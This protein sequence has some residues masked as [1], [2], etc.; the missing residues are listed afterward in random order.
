MDNVIIYDAARTQRG[1]MKDML[2][3]HSSVGASQDSSVAH[4]KFDEG[5]GSTA[6]NSGSDENAL[7]G[8][9]VGATWTSSGKYEKALDFDGSGD[10]VTVTN[11]S[12][13]MLS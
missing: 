4:W 11:L 7:N 2:N 13:G 9:I 1:I 6:Y 5:T 10:S 12:T 3:Q 8:A